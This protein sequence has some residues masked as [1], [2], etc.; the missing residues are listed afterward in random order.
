M[1]LPVARVQSILQFGVVSVDDVMNFSS[2]ISVKPGEDFVNLAGS[3]FE[4]WGDY[5]GIARKHN[6]ATRT[7][8]MA[9]C[10]GNTSNSWTT[11]IAEIGGTG[12]NVEEV[13][14]PLTETKVYP[15]PIIDMFHL[16]FE[17]D[18][19]TML[20]IRI[21]DIQGR[22]VK[23]LY[24]GKGKPGTNRFFFNKAALE[25]GTYIIKISDEKNEYVN[26]KIVVAE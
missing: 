24:Y 14:Q 21:Y 19:R 6:A 10:Y 3:S 13:E 1:H 5:T 8:W 9:A 16:E 23:Q 17:L 20:D 11:H 2:S 4:R 26:Q 12:T 18:V 25:A 22:E 15:N 7:V